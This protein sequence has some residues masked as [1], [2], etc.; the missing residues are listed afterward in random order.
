MKMNFTG[1]LQKQNESLKKYCMY[2]SIMIE[3]EYNRN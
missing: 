1:I 2:V 3:F